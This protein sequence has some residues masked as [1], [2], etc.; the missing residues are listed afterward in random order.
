[1]E[2]VV[3]T[4]PDLN[5]IQLRVYDVYHVL[6]SIV[7]QVFGKAIKAFAEPFQVVV[8]RDVHAGAGIFQQPEN[9]EFTSSVRR[10]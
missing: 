10:I 1:L 2:D 5:I 7:R 9:I 8:W 3:Q 6:N 4:R